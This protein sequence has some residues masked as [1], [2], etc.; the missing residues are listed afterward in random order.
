MRFGRFGMWWRRCGVGA[1]CLGASLV[2]I[3]STSL[4]AGCGG[5]DGSASSSPSPSPTPTP[6]VFPTLPVSPS[7]QPSGT[8]SLMVANPSADA[9]VNPT[10]VPAAVTSG[11]ITQYNQK[12]NGIT[13]TAVNGSIAGPDTYHLTLSVSNSTASGIQ[14]GQIYAIGAGTGTAVDL[15]YVEYPTTTSTHQWQPQSGQGSLTIDS[16]SG[17]T[18]AL[19]GTAVFSAL[20]SPNNTAVGSFTLNFSTSVVLPTN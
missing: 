4:L 6:T 11:A 14:T 15:S 9:N 1:V 20:T 2:T 18:V 5:G 13:L 17:N 8:V 19:H 10:P 16:I 3:G 7:P 12:P